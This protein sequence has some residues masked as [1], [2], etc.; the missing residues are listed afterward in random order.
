MSHA[1]SRAG[2]KR[3]RELTWEEVLVGIEN[4]PALPAWAVSPELF[5][6]LNAAD[7]DRFLDHFELSSHKRTLLRRLEDCLHGKPLP[8][9]SDVTWKNVPKGPMLESSTRKADTTGEMEGTVEDT[10]LEVLRGVFARNFRNVTEMEAVMRVGVVVLCAVKDLEVTVQL[11]PSLTNHPT[12][13]D[14]LFVVKSTG[15]AI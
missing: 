5:C 8:A 13:T 15:Q 1:S 14:F 10:F 9:P 4:P 11:Q 2:R 3:A 12:F 6:A 7:Q